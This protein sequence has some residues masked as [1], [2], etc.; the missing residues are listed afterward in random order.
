MLKIKISRMKIVMSIFLVII[1][2]FGAKYK[3]Q[4]TFSTNRWIKYPRERVK[5]VDDMLQKHKLVGQTKKD[6]V[7]LLGD[8]TNTDYFKEDNNVV[9]YLG[10]ERG[11]ISIDSE[12]LVIT[13]DNN[14]VVEVKIETD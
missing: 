13:F 3:Y 1:I 10:D 4:H 6:I 8:A 2:F 7:K 9:Y 5:M 11:F 14:I 12:W